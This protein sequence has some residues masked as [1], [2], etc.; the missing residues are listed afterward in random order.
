VEAIWL[1]AIITQ[2]V[3]CK[4]SDYTLSLSV[5]TREYLTVR[6]TLLVLTL[7]YQSWVYLEPDPF[8][9]RRLSGDWG[10]GPLFFS[11]SHWQQGR[12]KS[13]SGDRYAVTVTRDGSVRFQPGGSAVG[14]WAR[15]QDS[16]QPVQSGPSRVTLVSS[17]GGTSLLLVVFG[18]P[19]VRSPAHSVTLLS[20]FTPQSWRNVVVVSCLWPS[21]SEEPS[22]FSHAVVCFHST[23]LAERR[24]C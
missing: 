20:V 7:R 11:P 1:Y 8:G 15:F 12:Q 19:W 10:L 14:V 18:R 3:D 9:Q 23:A 5:W 22:S 21:V 13:V 6:C 16:H 17:V 4:L 24:C 2:C